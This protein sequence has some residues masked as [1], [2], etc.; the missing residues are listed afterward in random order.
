MMHFVPVQRLRAESCVV[1]AIVLSACADGTPKAKP[2]STAVTPVASSSA[3][4]ASTVASADSTR[5]VARGKATNSTSPAVADK[6]VP[7]RRIAFGGVDFTGIGYDRG[8]ATAPV[9]VI[10]LSDF[11]CPY[12]GEFAH[13]VFPSIDREYIQTGNVLFKYIPFVAGSFRHATEATRAAECAADQGQFWL[14]MERL[15]ITQAE[16]KSGNVAD[17]QMAALAG[18][19]PIDS[20]KFVSCYASRRTDSRTARATAVANEIGVRVTPSF[21]VDGHPVQGALPVAEFRKQIETALLVESTR[22]PS[23]RGVLR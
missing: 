8:S 23:P 5:P 2:D 21:L 18:T 12:C 16:W 7:A 4:T 14:M 9:V 22:K 6:T 1:L 13:D 10:D 17:A 19:L 11:A 20:V 15:Y 3:P